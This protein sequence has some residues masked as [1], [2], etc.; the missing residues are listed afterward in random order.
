MRRSALSLDG[1]ARDEEPLIIYTVDW[2]GLELFVPLDLTRAGF[3]TVLGVWDG[4]VGTEVQLGKVYNI[5][6]GRRDLQ[7][8]STTSRLAGD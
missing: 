3:F 8:N 4:D 2:R 7:R 6:I 5:C 1:S